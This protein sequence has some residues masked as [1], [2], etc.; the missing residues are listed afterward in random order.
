MGFEEAFKGLGG[1][2]RQGVGVGTKDEVNENAFR[3]DQVGRRL[4]LCL[5]HELCLELWE[6]E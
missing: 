1:T 3:V 4:C 5:K 2:W 6:V